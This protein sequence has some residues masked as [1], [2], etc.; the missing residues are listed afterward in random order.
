M[1]L[2]YFLNPDH[3]RI[4]VVAGNKRAL[5]TQIGQ[6]AAQLGVDA[7]EVSAALADRERQ[8]TTGFGDGIAIP[9]ARIP[10]LSAVHGLVL[11]LNPPVDYRAL[12][13]RDVDLV[14]ALLSPPDA[15]AE[16]LQALATISRLARN[17]A[18]TAK[19]RGARSRDA[20][21]AV[22]LAGEERDAA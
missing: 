5:L 8:G 2:A 22:L 12:D 14:F 1:S 16:H 15:T 3:V 13:G 17:H 4:D 20:L 9:H 11:R 10:G 6:L 19:L 7:A 18:Y 21:V